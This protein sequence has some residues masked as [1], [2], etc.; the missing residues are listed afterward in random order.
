MG[1]VGTPKG[2]SL[3]HNAI[4]DGK[5]VTLEFAS[6]RAPKSE[7]R[8]HTVKFTVENGNSVKSYSVD[9]DSVESAVAALTE[10]LSAVGLNFDVKEVTVYFE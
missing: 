2:L 1:A 9:T 4:V 5:R 8:K 6:T 7:T 10:A 3:A